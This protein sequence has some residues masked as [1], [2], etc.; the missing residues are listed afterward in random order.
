M[1][2]S[3]ITCCF[4]EKKVWRGLEQAEVI[5]AS[6]HVLSS[7][8]VSLHAKKLICLVCQAIL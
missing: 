4:Y 5:T 2:E 6:N 1:Q 3:D 7:T 8:G